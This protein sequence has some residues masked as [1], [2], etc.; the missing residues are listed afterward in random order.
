MTQNADGAAPTIEASG[1]ITALDRPYALVSMEDTG[2]GRC[3]E[4]GGCG[5]NTMSKLFCSTPR[6]F[7]VLN[8]GALGI[9]DRVTVVIAEGAVRRSAALAYGCP[10]LALF[11][12]ALAGS[13]FAGESGAMAGS[14][15]GVIAAWAAL[16]GVHR[17]RAAKSRCE[18][19]I[20]Y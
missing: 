6:T 19:Y 11:A 20:K 13:F 10:L 4:T 7:R 8:R 18:P 2:C 1:T 17:R 9:G 15:C 12:G 3:H 14:L 16:H 5:G